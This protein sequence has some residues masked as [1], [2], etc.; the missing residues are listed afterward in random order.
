[1]VDKEQDAKVQDIPKIKTKIKVEKERIKNLQDLL[2]DRVI[3]SDDYKD[4][5]GR[6]SENIKDLEK[7]LK[8][9][10]QNKKGLEQYLMSSLNLIKNLC[11]TYQTSTTEFKQRLV[12]S[13]FPKKLSFDGNQ[14]RT[15]VL[16]EVVFW[17]LT[18]SKGFRAKKNEQLLKK[19]QLFAVVEPEGIEPS[20]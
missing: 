6:Y 10:S 5:R 17:I 14:C 7:E 8:K 16:Q 20:S 19:L 15:P 3:G 1:M 13:I 4:M 11:N 2:A 12:G 18:N 9:I